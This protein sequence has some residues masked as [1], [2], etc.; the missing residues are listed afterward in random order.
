M[1][2]EKHI[3]N[4]EKEI[5]NADRTEWARRGLDTYSYA[6]DIEDEPLEANFREMLADLMHL[7]DNFGLDFHTE[8]KAARVHYEAE[9]SE[10]HGK[11]ALPPADSTTIA[12]VRRFFADHPD[13][14]NLFADWLVPDN[15]ELINEI[16]G[17]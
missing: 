16:E 12:N 14:G 11:D 3:T 8:A 4:P 5:T 9:Y 13:V 7:A 6:K 1:N 10:E 15:Q 17:I 2:V